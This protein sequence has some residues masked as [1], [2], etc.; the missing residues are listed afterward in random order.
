MVRVTIGGQVIMIT[1]FLLLIIAPYTAG[2]D[3]L[4]TLAIICCEY[5]FPIE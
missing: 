4:N 2:C 3:M 1:H 5:P